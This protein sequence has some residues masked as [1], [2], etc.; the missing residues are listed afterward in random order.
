[1]A[2]AL[3]NQ[4]QAIERLPGALKEQLRDSLVNSGADA[5]LA[6]LAAGGTADQAFKGYDNN[7][8]SEFM[9][10]GNNAA[11]AAKLVDPGRFGEN[12]GANPLTAQML[13]K[14]DVD[15][16][17]NMAK[18]GKGDAAHGVI[19]AV[20]KIAKAN[21]AELAGTGM[22]D[23]QI[24]LLQE[25]TKKMLSELESIGNQQSANDMRFSGGGPTPSGG[26]SRRVKRS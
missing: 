26:P 5:P 13:M 12:G 25:R 15:S 17:S 16:V 8:L 3:A 22:A 7:K 4:P 21:A 2:K 1:M 20:E 18:E 19:D 14:L 11:A 23:D 9:G 24:R 6:V 10:K